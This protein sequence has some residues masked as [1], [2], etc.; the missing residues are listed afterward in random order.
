M[1]RPDL[2][3]ADV[4]LTGLASPNLALEPAVHPFYGRHLLA[5]LYGVCRAK[6]DDPELLAGALRRGTVQSGA[7][8]LNLEVKRFDPQ[9]VTV[10]ALLAES[11]ASL[12]TYPEV[13]ALFFDA[14]TCGTCDPEAILTAVV[15]A[16]EPAEVERRFLNRG[17]PR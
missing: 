8:L 12:H 14:F 3:P 11:H 2:L 7:T 16:L 6:L 5:E 13:G 4:P 1:I 9:G 10:L 15:A 17:G